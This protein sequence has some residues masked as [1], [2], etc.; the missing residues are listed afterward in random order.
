[1]GIRIS[2]FI[3]ASRDRVFEACTD[4][5]HWAEMIEG[6]VKVERLDDGPP[7]QGTRFRETRVMFK[8]EHTEEMWFENFDPPT[9][10]TVKGDSCGSTYESVFTFTEKDG[11]TQMDMEMRWKA[12]TLFAKLMAPMGALMAGPMKKAMTKDFEDIK[13]F[14]EAPE[15]AG[16]A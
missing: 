7:G 16:V 14:L 10:Y 13:A 12:N 11:G 1:M 9:G 4:V 5:D 8:K 3:A 2:T 15:G 6:I